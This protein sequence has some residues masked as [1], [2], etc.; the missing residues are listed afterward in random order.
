MTWREAAL[1]A[2]QLRPALVVPNHYDLYLEN[3][4]DPAPF[5]ARCASLGLAAQTLAA[6]TPFFLPQPS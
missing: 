2:E 5:L 1:L 6:G 4:A 3:Q